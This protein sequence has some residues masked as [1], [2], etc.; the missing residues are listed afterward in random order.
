MGMN[1]SMRT[2][3]LIYLPLLL[4]L[5]S[6]SYL[7]GKAAKMG[8]FD[9]HLK[10]SN[11]TGE[12]KLVG[13]VELVNP[14]Q[15][16]V[17][18]NCDQRHN[19]PV[20]TEII[21]QSPDGT[22]AKLKVSPE[23]KGNYITADITE[24]EPEVRDLVLWQIRPGDVLPGEAATATP[25]IP[26]SPPVHL[27]PIMPAD[28]IPPLG[29]PFQPMGEQPLAPAPAPTPRPLRQAPAPLPEGIPLEEPTPDPSKLPPVIR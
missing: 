4:G 18:I 23:R 8:M 1:G 14:E 19:L 25:S 12:A 16:Y 29:T 5:S 11:R 24:G 27:T 22:K 3:R 7:I 20:G 2:L 9:K 13:T 26:E 17:L 10:R 15:N 6:C 21:A 28:E